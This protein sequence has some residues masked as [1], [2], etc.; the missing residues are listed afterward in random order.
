[1]IL[2]ESLP[3]SSLRYFSNAGYDTTCEAYSRIRID[4]MIAAAKLVYMNQHN[5]RSERPATTQLKPE[6]MRIYPEMELT[7]EVD[8]PNHPTKGGHG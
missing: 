8:D 3:D 7:V 2:T 4:C 5:P 1:M 6:D